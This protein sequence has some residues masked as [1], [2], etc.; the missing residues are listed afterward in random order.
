VAALEGH[1]MVAM[2]IITIIME[3]LGM[4]DSGMEVSGMEVS[5]MGIMEAFTDTMEDFM[6]TMEDSM[7]IAGI[8]EIDNSDVLALPFVTLYLLAINT[9]LLLKCYDQIIKD[10]YHTFSFFILRAESFLNKKIAC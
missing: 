2:T 5:T 1:T 6:D 7:D 4:E 9:I 3:D 10:S 8:A